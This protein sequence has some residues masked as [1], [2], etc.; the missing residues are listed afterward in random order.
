[1]R[2]LDVAALT[3]DEEAAVLE[4]CCH[5]SAST[6][7]RRTRRALHEVLDFVQ[8]LVQ[9]RN[10]N[11]R[12][13]EMSGFR[14]WW[15][16]CKKHSVVVLNYTSLDGDT[17]VAAG[18]DRARGAVSRTK[19][20]RRYLRNAKTTQVRLAAH[21]YVTTSDANE[22]FD[23]STRTLAV[24]APPALVSLASAPISSAPPASFGSTPVSLV[25]A[26]SS[27]SSA[28]SPLALAPVSVT[29]SAGAWNVQ[30]FLAAFN[31]LSDSFFAGAP[32]QD[33]IN[34]LIKEESVN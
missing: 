24:S 14:W 3:D 31:P 15:A 7:N 10:P 16:F 33:I 19:A 29:S 6:Y 28:P 30:Q 12:F 26:L 17:F 18:C 34:S 4:F 5:V 13:D 21:A 22:P 32:V 27:M 9:L 11:F 8:A 23:F 20:V 2:G 1:M 25:P